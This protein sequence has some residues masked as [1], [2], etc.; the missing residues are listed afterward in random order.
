MTSEYKE[1]RKI[2]SIISAI[3]FMVIFYDIFSLGVQDPIKFSIIKI[4]FIASFFLPIQLFKIPKLKN[5]ASSLT[6]LFF[7]AYVAYYSITFHYSYHAAYI[8]FFMAGPLIFKLKKPQFLITHVIGLIVFLWGTNYIPPGIEIEYF[9]KSI[10]E[11]TIIVWVFSFFW[12][13]SIHKINEKFKEQEKKFAELGKTSSFLLH[14]IQAPLNRLK[15][16]HHIEEERVKEI[17]HIGNILNVS[18]AIS[19][20][21]LENIQHEPINIKNIIDNNIKN[22]LNAIR[23][24]DIKLDVTVADCDLK[25]NKELSTI[26][27]KNLIQNAV[28]HLY[29]LENTKN[30]SL[31]IK[32][33]K[34][35][36][37][38]QFSISNNYSK[39]KSIKV[40]D[41]FEPLFSTKEG[42]MSR[43]LG[44]FIC[45]K[46]SEVLN[47]DI[48]NSTNEDMI[49]F[50]CTWANHS[51]FNV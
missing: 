40:S 37:N 42:V 9:I 22:Y 26:I 41:M 25:T 12:Y 27:I 19:S 48:T 31:I 8:E 13:F 43:G 39:S 2:I 32:G 24:D 30:K 35:K 18:Q 21:K 23:F 51:H 3:A 1:N 17:D 50:E 14:E 45:K 20:K 44:L 46:I 38:Y 34:Q 11:V 36:D 29:S 4:L 16:N 5:Y 15:S 7:Y 49:K 6:M 33:I 28:E 10:K 47:L